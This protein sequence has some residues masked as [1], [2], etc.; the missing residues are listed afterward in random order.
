MRMSLRR[1]KS[2]SCQKRKQLD[3]RIRLNHLQ[4][5]ATVCDLYPQSC[6]PMGRGNCELKPNLAI[7][8]MVSLLR[9]TAPN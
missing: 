1:H 9:S 5:N 7:N 6:I 2:F 4:V 3:L 8:H